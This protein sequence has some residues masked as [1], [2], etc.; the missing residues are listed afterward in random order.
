MN[1]SPLSMPHLHRLPSAPGHI[2]R[3]VPDVTS[4]ASACSQLRHSM[5]QRFARAFQPHPKMSPNES[6][7]EHV[8]HASVCWPPDSREIQTP[9]S[10]SP[11]H[12]TRKR[13]KSSLMTNRALSSTPQRVP[14][15]YTVPGL[16]SAA[17][18]GR[19]C[20]MRKTIS[21]SV[22][23]ASQTRRRKRSLAAR[24]TKPGGRWKINSSRWQSQTRPMPRRR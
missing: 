16:C 17:H 14:A 4:A 6:G 24:W 13:S 8:P 23:C 11:N 21:R 12:V 7:R 22:S 15:I 5:P 2:S 19:R 18:S 10:C 9:G 3:A 20:A 1:C